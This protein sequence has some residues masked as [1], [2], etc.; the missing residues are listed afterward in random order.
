MGAETSS[1]GFTGAGGRV[2]LL[3]PAGM[4]ATMSTSRAL[5]RCQ[6]FKLSELNLQS[7]HSKRMISAGSRLH[8]YD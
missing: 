2:S 6:L 1:S 7:F 3:D 8:R 5:W 4:L